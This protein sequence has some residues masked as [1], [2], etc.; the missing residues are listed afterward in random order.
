[1]RYSIVRKGPRRHSGLPVSYPQDMKRLAPWLALAIGLLA[2]Q[3]AL[4]EDSIRCGSRLA[5]TGD[6][7]YKVRL[8]CGEPADVSIVG[9][10]REPRL[11]FHNSRYYYLDP[12]WA[13]VPVEV[14]TYNL[15]PNKLMRTLRFEGEELVDIRTIGYG[16]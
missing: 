15:G 16:Y 1:M 4:A 5:S 10:M 6:F 11:W 12:P 7:K 8:L 14:W 2:T 3:I 13:Y 9:T